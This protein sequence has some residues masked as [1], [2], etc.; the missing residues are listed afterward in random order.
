MNSTRVKQFDSFMING[1]GAALLNIGYSYCC[2]DYYRIIYFKDHKIKVSEYSKDDFDALDIDFSASAF[3][4]P[5][6]LPERLAEFL[7][8]PVELVG[9]SLE[10]TPDFYDD[11][12]ETE[13]M[14]T[15]LLSDGFKYIELTISKEVE[16]YTENVDKQELPFIHVK[17]YMDYKDTKFY[18]MEKD[19]FEGYAYKLYKPQGIGKITPYVMTRGDIIYASSDHDLPFSSDMSTKAP[20]GI[21]LGLIKLIFLSDEKDHYTFST[22][23]I[24]DKYDCYEHLA[25]MQY[26]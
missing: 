15:V 2:G 24:Y 21:S 3:I 7:D 5:N 25:D 10:S 1:E 17:E 14:H 11:M 23:I 22:G 9:F 20:I 6:Q 19:E 4:S 16:F 12:D 8:R 18:R 13:V 26:R